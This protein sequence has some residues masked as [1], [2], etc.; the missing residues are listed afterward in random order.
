MTPGKIATY[1]M[2]FTKALKDALKALP[3]DEDTEAAKSP[4]SAKS[5]GR[6]LPTSDQLTVKLPSTR[7]PGE[8]DEARGSALV[9]CSPDA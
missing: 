6:R 8:A 1:T 7:K 9:A 2:K 3:P 4:R 5:I